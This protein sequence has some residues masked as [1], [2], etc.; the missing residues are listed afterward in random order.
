MVAIGHEHGNNS[1]S[2]SAPRVSIV[3]PLFNRVLFTQVC[4]RALAATISPEQTEVLFVDNGS[5]DG[6]AAFLAALPPPF[7]ALRSP[8][9][10]GFADA[11]NRGATAARGQYVLFLNNDT[12]PQPGWLD[13]LLAPL[14]TTGRDPAPTII[15]A[16]LLFP[17]DTV[18]HAGIGF[19]A[20]NEPVHRA[21]GAPLDDATA[22]RS[23]P[24]PAV[25]GACLLMER[26]RF[27]ALD[28]FDDGYRNGFEDLDLCC[29]VRQGGGIV[30]Y[31]AESTLY[32]FES[33]S[34]G[35]YNADEANYRRFHARWADWLATDPLAQ[36]TVHA[37]S[38][39]VRLNRTYATGADIRR[40][41]DRVIADAATFT[42]EFARLDAA[43][44][45]L[46]EAFVRQEAW[47][48]SL[49]ADAR[50]VRDRARWQRLVGRLLRM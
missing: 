44:G 35:R 13:A 5:T 18:Q 45:D 4:M 47:A 33:A 15:G 24:V 25:T 7:R 16:R 37:A 46:T 36:E 9:N 17:D 19:N 23:C 38:G 10:E 6:T 34:A 1:A 31:A 28:G 22:L 26:A 2:E 41:L 50:R 12:V 48:Q 14:V 32:H 11:C 39:P 40:E 42:A 29:R 3:I 49:E 27:L 8:T 30:W 21:Y 43:Y 20:R